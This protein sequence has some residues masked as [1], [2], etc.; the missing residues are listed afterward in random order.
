MKLCKDC[1]HARFQNPY[2]N[3][4]PVLRGAPIRTAPMCGSPSAPSDFVW[5]EPMYSCEE[6]R[7]PD[8]VGF[9][10]EDA[11]LFEER[12]APEPS[13]DAG[14]IV[15]MQPQEDLKRSWIA[16]IFGR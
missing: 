12:P 6:M 2:A 7:R 11:K 5:G 3:A 15:Y 1:K 13:P 14:S 4:I 9:C 16:R 10:G 8:L